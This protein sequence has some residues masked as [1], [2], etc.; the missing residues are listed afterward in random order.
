MYS[1]KANEYNIQL[2]KISG[3]L[4]DL[5][6]SLINSNQYSQLRKVNNYLINVHKTID[7]QTV[8][9]AAS[10]AILGVGAVYFGYA[11]KM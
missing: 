3:Y 11:F 5:P 10:A 9:I 1:L 8:L 7:T 2:N 6:K 4:H